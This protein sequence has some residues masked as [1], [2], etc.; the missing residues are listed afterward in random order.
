MKVSDTAEDAAQG[1]AWHGLNVT[2]GLA[3]L[4]IVYG[5]LG[6]SPLYVM[7]A[8]LGALPHPDGR[9]AL[10][11]LSLIVWALI[12]TI[13]IKYCVF[14]MR[15][16]N[17][18]EGGILALMTL[19]G[20]DADRRRWPL[21]AMGLFGAAL[22]YGDGIIT[23]AISV[24]SAVEGIN[25]ATDALKPYVLPIV[26]VILVALFA[27]QASGTAR[28]GRI[29]GPV[30]LVWFV[31]AAALGVAALIRRPEVLAA[32]NPA[33]AAGFLL[34]EGWRGF[35]V[36]GG[37][38]LAVTGGEALYADMGHVGRQPIRASWYG[39]VLPALLLNYAGQTALLLDHPDPVG[40]LFFLLAPGWAVV[41]LVLLATLATIIASQAIISGAF[42]L[43]RQAMQLGWLPGL[44]VRQ[45]SAAAYGQVYV[46]FVN[47]IMMALTLA[48]ALLFGSSDRL[49]GAYGTA[50]STTMLLTTVLLYYAMRERWRWP[51]PLALV[52]VAGFLLL[53]T[54][55]FAANLLKIADGGWIPLLAG[56]ALFA[57]MTTWRRGVDAIRDRVLPLADPPERF[58]QRLKDGNIPRVPGAAVFLTRN[59]SPVPLIMV[60][61]IA[62]MGAL[63]A[64]LVSLTVQFEQVPRVGLS[65]RVRV[66]QVFA[67]FWHISVRWGFM[68][69]PDLSAALFCARA[70]GCTVDFDHALF[71]GARDEV[72][73][74]HKDRQLP[75]W[76]RML[77]AFLYRNAV[78]TVDRFNLPPDRF[79]EVGRQIEV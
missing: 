72:I 69:V 57:V 73:A 50:V 79:I 48:L 18:G 10:G 34:R 46:P 27:A 40:S 15:A 77:F 59:Q 5:D 31:V 74:G 38:F 14:V 21:V 13:S 54:A 17:R 71:F 70:H 20:A 51:L 44:V 24:L 47:W 43:T 8:V 3:A 35:G 75:F 65:E 25:V 33:E 2:A 37:V 60:R 68:D 61:H 28:I 29:F 19:I 39:I 66:E 76:R 36:L 55:F 41:P 4:G 6:T 62:E 53:D 30:M 78:R 16:D 1:T 58:L 12:V 23:P 22:I 42:S 63:H 32:L 49:A 52:V 11:V 9:A 26:A 56:A 7:Q 45:T 67:D 64:K